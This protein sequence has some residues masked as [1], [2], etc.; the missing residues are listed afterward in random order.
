VRRKLAAILNDLAC[1]DKELSVLFVDDEEMHR[2]NH[3]YLG[4][5]GST[6]VIAFPM[7]ETDAPS[8]EGVFFD[9]PMLGDVVVCTDTAAREAEASGESMEA[10]VDRLLIHGILHLLGHD[11]ETSEQ[12]AHQMEKEERRLRRLLR[13]V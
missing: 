10:V 2:L 11:H 4:R 6:N 8:E 1:H 5:D 12:D 3:R 13:E 9:S 7:K